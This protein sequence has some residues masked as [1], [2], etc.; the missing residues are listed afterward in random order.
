VVQAS[1]LGCQKCP[2]R[3]KPY[4]LVFET[5]QQ[6]PPAQEDNYRLIGIGMFSQWLWLL[7]QVTADERQPSILCAATEPTKH[8]ESF[9]F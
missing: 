2:P 3:A 4:I 8:R 9:K 5:P 6:V 1:D 7:G